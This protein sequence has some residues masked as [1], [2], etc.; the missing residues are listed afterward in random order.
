[1]VL[2]QELVEFIHSPQLVLE[3]QHKLHSLKFMVHLSSELVLLLSLTVVTL[4]LFASL[5][6]DSMLSVVSQQSVER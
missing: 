6:V 1:M 3:H 4:T 5:M 2:V